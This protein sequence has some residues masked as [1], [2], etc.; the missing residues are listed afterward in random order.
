MVEAASNHQ[1]ALSDPSR[2]DSPLASLSKAP[3]LNQN[4]KA[5]S[6][7]NAAI[8]KLSQDSPLLSQSG[9]SDL[10]CSQLQAESCLV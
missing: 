6:E 8:S 1:A 7:P 10:M 5:F 2:P 3:N 4:E 9:F